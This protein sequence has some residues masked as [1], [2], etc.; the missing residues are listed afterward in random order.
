[1]TFYEIAI[2]DHDGS[3]EVLWSS[4]GVQIVE[5]ATA[6]FRA[7]RTLRVT[8]VES[9]SSMDAL[10]AL[11]KIT[12]FIS[13]EILELDGLDELDT[14]IPGHPRA[15]AKTILEA[16]NNPAW[17]RFTTLS[18]VNCTFLQSYER[19]AL[20]VLFKG[21][22]ANVHTLKLSGEVALEF[23][24]FD[25]QTGDNVPRLPLDF[26]TIDMSEL[27]IS[28]MHEV[29][30][31][32]ESY[33]SRC[34]RYE[35]R[36]AD[37]TT[38]PCIIFPPDYSMVEPDD[39]FDEIFLETPMPCCYRTNALALASTAMMSYSHETPL[40]A[41][42]ATFDEV[43]ITHALSEHLRDHL[44]VLGLYRGGFVQLAEHIIHGNVWVT[45][46]APTPDEFAVTTIFLARVLVEAT[47]DV[48][49]SV[50]AIATRE[51]HEVFAE[52]LDSVSSV[53]NV[54][55]R[56]REVTG[57]THPET[58]DAFFPVWTDETSEHW[59]RITQ[60]PRAVSSVLAIGTPRPGDCLALW[61]VDTRNIDLINA[62]R[63]FAETRAH[64]RAF[65]H[66]PAAT[67]VV[68][69]VVR[70]FERQFGTPGH[71]AAAAAASVARF[72]TMKT[73]DAIRA[74]SL[75]HQWMCT[76]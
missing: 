8:C 36:H 67:R 74:V 16:A 15:V 11:K 55:P 66:W 30:A 39:S 71:T 76:A 57:L 56:Y 6:R 61:A 4:D 63:H 38:R 59:A 3:E 35:G 41:G 68:G 73:I 17:N 1:M 62:P 21:L 33:M 47:G 19:K 23:D 75:V 51:H 58:I 70:A 44:R 26:A 28:Q 54:L 46:F 22:P 34:M 37:R 13:P 5:P 29:S 18:L 69:N 53:Y 50:D 7:V 52:A 32:T 45:R 49:S 24:V 31:F 40:P 14:R 20:T 2:V 12:G 43:V 48:E 42:P 60:D 65:Q 27:D 9:F 72:D 10:R 25:P 64:F